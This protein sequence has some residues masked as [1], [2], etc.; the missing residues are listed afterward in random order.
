MEDK[1]GK[2]KQTK[3]QVNIFL[4]WLGIGEWNFASS[5]KY[6]DCVMFKKKNQN[7]QTVRFHEMWRPVYPYSKRYQL[8]VL[9]L[10]SEHFKLED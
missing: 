1:G 5:R 2:T 3:Q 8:S 9:I 4:K 10:V 6:F 7:P